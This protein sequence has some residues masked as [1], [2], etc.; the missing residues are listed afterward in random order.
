MPDF[1]PLPHK[2]RCT[3]GRIP[4]VRIFEDVARVIA[5]AGILASSTP[6]QTVFCTKC[7]EIV[8]YS[9]GDVGM[10]RDLRST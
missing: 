4:P 2:C 5:R 1:R 9:A 7:K 10:G 6:V 8:I 3:G